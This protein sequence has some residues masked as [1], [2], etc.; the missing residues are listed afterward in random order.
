[1]NKKL[2]EWRGKFLSQGGKEVLIKAVALAIPNSTISVF[3]LPSSFCHD[4]HSIIA[5][6]WRGGDESKTQNPL[7]DMGETVFLNWRAV[8]AFEI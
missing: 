6:F 1:M 4:Q 2:Q 7:A 8:S 5:W 3:R